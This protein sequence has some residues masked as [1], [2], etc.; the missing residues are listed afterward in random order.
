MTPKIV[1]SLF[2][3]LWL[4]AAASAADTAFLKNAADSALF[5]VKLGE[6][7]ETNA[8]S[9]FVKDFGQRMVTDHAG[10]NQSVQDLAGRRNIAL[11]SDITLDEKSSYQR[12]SKKTGTAFDKAYI[13]YM[14]KNHEADL[15][16]FQKEADSGTD[17]D[18]KALAAKA[19]LEIKEHLRLARQNAKQLG[20]TL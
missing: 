6:L 11:P 15:A 2:G 4:C 14:V 1:Y 19:I 10:M 13:S 18:A 16:L 8:S 20:L 7:A 3:L 9:Q 12:L 5:E 17:A